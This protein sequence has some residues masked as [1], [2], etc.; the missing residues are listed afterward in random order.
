MG[1]NYR[2]RKI[3]PRGTAEERA[4]H[5]TREARLVEFDGE[6]TDRQIQHC[7]ELGIPRWPTLGETAY[8]INLEYGRLR[9]L[10]ATDGNN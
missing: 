4:Y 8:A 3:P 5:R 9:A 6:P 1:A 2:I 10:E 7:M